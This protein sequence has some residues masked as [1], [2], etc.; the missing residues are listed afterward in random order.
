MNRLFRTLCVIGF[1]GAIVN[2][3]EYSIGAAASYIVT[4]GERAV[5]RAA[6]QDEKERRMQK[7]ARYT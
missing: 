7:S 5:R 1:T 6:D 4:N 2:T 3:G